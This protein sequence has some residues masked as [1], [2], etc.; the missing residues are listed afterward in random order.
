[1]TPSHPT[2]EAILDAAEQ[3]FA[4]KGLTATTIKDIGEASRTNT[5]L[6]YYH[7]QDKE[8]LYREVLA[9]M[10]G[11]LIQ[12]GLA[13]LR[14]ATSPEE[15]IRGVVRAQVA[16]VAARP[17]LPALFVREMIEHGAQRG[18]DLIHQL[19]GQLFSGLCQVIEAGQR[20]GDFR[21]D[22][23]PRLAAISTISQVM[24]F[25]VAQP[26]IRILMRSGG[27]NTPSLEAFGEHAAEFAVRALRADGA[28]QGLAEVKG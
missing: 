10:A 25:A 22:I 17:A 28:W 24:Y 20:S 27:E 2:R 19:A 3:L 13:A 7:F 18:E 8:G 5:A 15:G 23:D 4:S 12:R 16:M 11:G 9:R 6:L 14:T 26:A 21:R 1:M